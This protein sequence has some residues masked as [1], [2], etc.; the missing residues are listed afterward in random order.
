MTTLDPIVRRW[1]KSSRSNDNGSCVECASVRWVKSSRSSGNGD[2]VEAASLPRVTAVR[3]SKHPEGG[4]LE[5]SS[6][7]WTALLATIRSA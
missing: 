1:V 5:L 4:H 7:D 3:D 2:C 6:V